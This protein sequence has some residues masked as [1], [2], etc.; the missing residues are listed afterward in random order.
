M[1]TYN[2][3]KAMRST[4]GV[5]VLGASLHYSSVAQ[6]AAAASPSAAPASG[7]ATTG[8]DQ[9]I[10]FDIAAQALDTALLRFS[11]QA[12]VQV[13]VPT[14]SITG[15]KTSGVQGK[16]IAEQALVALLKDSGLTYKQINTHTV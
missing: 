4:L 15:K 11:E 16:L 8:F 1:Q 10:K 2:Y 12:G 5:V 6:G 9:S 3:L 7:A 13:L 14:E